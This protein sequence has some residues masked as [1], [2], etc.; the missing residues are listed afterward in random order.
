MGLC[1]NQPKAQ[2]RTHM[3]VVNKKKWYRDWDFLVKATY[4]EEEIAFNKCVYAQ[5]RQSEEETYCWRRGCEWSNLRMVD[6]PT[7][8]LPSKETHTGPWVSLPTFFP[9]LLFP[10]FC[11][12]KWSSTNCSNA[13]SSPPST[14]ASISSCCWTVGLC[15]LEIHQVASLI[16]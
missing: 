2:A 14:W 10:W 15:C 7:P 5:M 6:L 9:P 12:A 13:L 11:P 16:T 3:H 8:I 4:W 1:I